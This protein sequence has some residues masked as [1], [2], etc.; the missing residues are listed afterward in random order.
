MQ[1]QNPQGWRVLTGFGGEVNT[2]RSDGVVGRVVVELSDKEVII[3]H[4]QR[5]LLHVCGQ[6]HMRSQ[7]QR[8]RSPCPVYKA[9][10][11]LTYVIY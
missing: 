2:Q 11:V 5:E 7:L 1:S 4:P 10:S 8:V 6:E 3:L 9:C